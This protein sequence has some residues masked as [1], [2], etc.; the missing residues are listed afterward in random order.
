V[1]PRIGW[2]G[3][4]CRVS[5]TASP[6][7]AGTAGP[8][9]YPFGDLCGAGVAFKLA[10]RLCTLACGSERVT[11]PLRELLLELLALTSLPV[12]AD[13]VPLLGENRVT[14]RA[15]PRRIKYSRIEGLRALVE[16]SG[17]SGDKA[18]EEDV[19][20]RIGPRLNACGRMDHAKDAVE[21]LTTAAGPRA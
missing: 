15:G 8:P 19:G 3:S 2:P 5:S 20:F 6:D 7:P 18:G 10:W 14:A 13:I 9:T 12:I 1:H 4:P 17:L 11:E 16:A 21:L